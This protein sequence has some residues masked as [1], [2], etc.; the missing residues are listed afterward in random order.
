MVRLRYSKLT[1][2]RWLSVKEF[3]R[4]PAGYLTRDQY[5]ACSADLKPLVR[6]LCNELT[7]ELQ[8]GVLARSEA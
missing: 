2:F 5:E 6:H 3:G 1:N 4:V 8:P 7:D